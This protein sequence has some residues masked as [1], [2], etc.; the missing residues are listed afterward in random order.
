MDGH[1]LQ[2]NCAA[3]GDYPGF[4]DTEDGFLAGEANVCG[5]AEFCSDSQKMYL[6]LLQIPRVRKPIEKDK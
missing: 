5:G 4:R 1:P 3:V 6:V 2:V